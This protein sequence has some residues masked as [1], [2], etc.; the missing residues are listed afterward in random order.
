MNEERLSNFLK[1]YKSRVNMYRR[2][3]I[4]ERQMKEKLNRQFLLRAAL[5]SKEEEKLSKKGKS[6]TKD[7]VFTLSKGDECFFE[8]IKLGRLAETNLEK[9]HTEEFIYPIGYK[10]RRIYIPYKQYTKDKMEYICDITEEGFSIVSE[11]KRA[12]RGPNM[13]KEFISCFSSPFEFKCMEHFFGLNYKPIMNKIEKLGDIS[14]FS[15]YIPY[16]ERKRK[17]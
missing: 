5:K 6:I 10:A 13:W 2:R 1:L 7:F 17:V 12:W 15:G 14:P 9:W 16:E 4:L 3:Y 8:M 11:D